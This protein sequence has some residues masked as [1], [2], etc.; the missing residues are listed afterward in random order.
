MSESFGVRHS[1]LVLVFQALAVV[2]VIVGVIAA[3]VLNQEYTGGTVVGVLAGTFVSFVSLQAVA[4]ALDLL[5][6][7]RNATVRQAELAAE[8]ARSAAP[9]TSRAAS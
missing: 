5:L 7:I 4:L 1:W 8:A 2:T 6:E 9:D 3:L